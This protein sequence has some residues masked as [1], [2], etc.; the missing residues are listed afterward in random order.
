MRLDFIFVSH[1]LL[2]QVSGLQQELIFFGRRLHFAGKCEE[3]V[4]G[5]VSGVADSIF[6]LLKGCVVKFAALIFFVEFSLNGGFKLA[7]VIKRH[8]VGREHF[9]NVLPGLLADFLNAAVEV[10]G[11]SDFDKGTIEERG[12]DHRE[13]GERLTDFLNVRL[14]AIDGV[15]AV[16]ADGRQDFGSHPAIEFF[17][18][19]QITA[20][21]ERVQP[22]LIDE[23]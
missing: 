18:F 9:L 6:N 19:G 14:F 12:V 17:R 16:L 3:L 20:Q 7:S 11:E 21:N 1:F 4:K 2:K 22:A 8:E 10:A 23:N 13:F 15:I 5:V